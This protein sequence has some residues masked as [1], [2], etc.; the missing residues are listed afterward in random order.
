[1][2]IIERAIKE[3]IKGAIIRTIAFFD[4]FDHPLTILEIRKYLY[5]PGLATD[6]G[7]GVMLSQLSLGLSDLAGRNVIGIKNGFYYLKGRDSSLDER[8]RRY[9]HTDQKIKR[10]LKVARLFSILPWIRMIAVGNMIGA[11]NLRP[12][13]DIDLFI[14]VRPHKIWTT[15]FFCNLITAG[16]NLRPKKDNAKDKICLS[17]FVT[18]D[19]LDL[20]GLSLEGDIYFYYWLA[21]LVPLYE[22]GS[23]YRKLVAANL[24]IYG[25]LPNWQPAEAAS[26]RNLDLS[27]LAFHFSKVIGLLTFWLEGILR[28]VQKRI[29]P[30]EIKNKLEKNSNVIVNDKLLKFHV[31]DRRIIY[32]DEWQRRALKARKGF[33]I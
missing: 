4:L 12:E 11:H 13:S 8:M 18:E 25:A 26:S 19:C 10:A 2:D 3:E 21:G 6:S 15:R 9:G 32:R 14:I 22:R 28:G 30:E 20:S 7:K 17:F 24:W 1:M 31:N 33:N 29:F 5:L 27:A 23:M 16:L